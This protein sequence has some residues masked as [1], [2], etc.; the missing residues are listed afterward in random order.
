M[1]FTV[2][3][4]DWQFLKIRIAPKFSYEYDDVRLI[5]GANVQN[6]QKKG[7]ND[8]CINENGTGRQTGRF[9]MKNMASFAIFLV[10]WAV[11]YIWSVPI[12]TCCVQNP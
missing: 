9:F 7:I 12:A 6:G 3:M 10:T 5:L 11:F 8:N 1:L 4:I 2:N